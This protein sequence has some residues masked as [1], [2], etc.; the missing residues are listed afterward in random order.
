MP[1]Y[2]NKFVKKIKYTDPTLGRRLFTLVNIDT[3]RKLLG[4]KYKRT[5]QIYLT[6]DTEKPEE[7]TKLCSEARA[8]A[9]KKRRADG[10]PIS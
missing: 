7:A 3:V 5:T 1:Q 9:N 6:Q 10:R 2:R 4:H 8:K